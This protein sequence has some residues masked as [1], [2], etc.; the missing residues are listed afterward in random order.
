MYIE[1]ED[2]KEF[3][4]ISRSDYDEMKRMVCDFADMNKDIVLGESIRVPTFAFK[5]MSRKLKILYD[6]PKTVLEMHGIDERF[7]KKDCDD[8]SVTII[9][10]AGFA[11]LK[12]TPQEKDKE[13]VRIQRSE[14]LEMKTMLEELLAKCDD[15][16]FIPKAVL[17]KLGFDYI[18][19]L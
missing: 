1:E 6:M 19:Y 17:E 7:R 9:L 10:R 13:Y 2:V 4:R 11:A 14:F 15:G 18:P 5:E 8:E 12:I 3:V 16:V